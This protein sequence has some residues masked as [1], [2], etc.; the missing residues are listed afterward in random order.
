MSRKIKDRIGIRYGRLI[1]IKFIDM[2]WDGSCFYSCWLCKC[3]CGKE[4]R[5]KGGN[6]QSG[7]TQSCGC[8]RQEKCS[9]NGKMY[10]GENNPNYIDGHKC[11]SIKER[12]RKRDNYTCQKCGKTQ[13]ELKG[14]HKKLDV[15][16]IDGDNTNNDPE[17][18]ITLCHNCHAKLCKEILYASR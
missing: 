17:N 4:V 15:H 7:M 12:I 9:E 13:K 1:V 6:L 16:H 5:I 11:T 10:T 2:V 18:M 8:L 3:D 14:R